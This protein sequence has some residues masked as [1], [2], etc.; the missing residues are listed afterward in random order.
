MGGDGAVRRMFV[1]SRDLICRRHILKYSCLV[2][3]ATFFAMFEITRRVA[4]RTKFA[5][6]DVIESWG[7]KF[8]EIRTR[9]LRRHV[10]RAVHGVTLVSGGVVAGLTYELVSRPFDVARQLV[11]QDKAVYARNHG[12]VPMAV[13]QKV[14]QD[15]IVIFFRDPSAGGTSAK[16]PGS[17][18]NRRLYVALRTFARVGP[19]GIG[20]L[21]W[22]AFGPGL[23]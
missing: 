15:G 13:M 19:W 12:S 11:R 6:Q 8:G 7:P 16:S 1:V 3:F 10:P 9:S 14:R 20:F 4:S 5:S 18:N 21:A 23:S 17:I 2:G 22:E